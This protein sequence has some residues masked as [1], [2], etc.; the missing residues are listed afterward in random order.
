[1]GGRAKPGDEG[2]PPQIKGQISKD[3]ETPTLTL[4]HKGR[5]NSHAVQARRREPYSPPISQ[6]SAHS[7]SVTG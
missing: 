1:M 2:L 5:G 6:I 7:G 3:G 4:P